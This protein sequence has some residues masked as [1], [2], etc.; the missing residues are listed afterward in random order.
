M[1]CVS[2]TASESGRRPKRASIPVSQR[3]AFTQRTPGREAGVADRI[4]H[5]PA[6]PALRDDVF[7]VVRQRVLADRG[8][9]LVGERQ[10]GQRVVVGVAPARKRAEHRRHQAEL[11]V[12]IAAG[13]RA[14]AQVERVDARGIEVVHAPVEQ[15]RDRAVE[16]GLGHQVDP[17]QAQRVGLVVGVVEEAPVLGRD[18]AEELAAEPEAS[19]E[20]RGRIVRDADGR[21][22]EPAARR[23]SRRACARRRSRSG[24]AREY[25][26]RG[27][28]LS[29]PGGPRASRAATRAATAAVPAAAR[30]SAR[31]LRARGPRRAPPRAR[32][33]AAARRRR[34]A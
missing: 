22:R 27:F 19:A 10:A 23:R 16:P 13:P 1:P 6:A 34:A 17:E 24:P 4:A 8:Q 29:R 26:R 12:E 7:G 31:H 9:V 18:R 21:G 33:R 25:S 3:S 28:G 2:A 14:H 5:Q 20:E 11:D 30:R 32:R 15:Q